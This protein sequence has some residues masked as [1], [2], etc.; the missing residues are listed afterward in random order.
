MIEI[1]C[2]RFSA[3]ISGEF[4]KDKYGSNRLLGSIFWVVWACTG[5]PNAAMTI[6]IRHT[7]LQEW[8]DVIAASATGECAG[9]LC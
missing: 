2:C 8:R 7:D 1:A 5:M 9:A 4:N 3:I 6:A